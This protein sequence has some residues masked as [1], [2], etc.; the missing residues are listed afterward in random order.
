LKSET[1]ENLGDATLET[2]S[3]QALLPP[4]QRQ[5]T[6]ESTSPT[7]QENPL[8]EGRKVGGEIEKEDSNVGVP[9]ARPPAVPD[10]TA[11]ISAQKESISQPAPSSTEPEPYVACSDCKEDI[12]NI[13]FHFT[14]RICL[15]K[16]KYTYQRCYT[17]KLR[18]L[19]SADH[20]MVKSKLKE[21]EYTWASFHTPMP[22]Y[23][24]EIA[25]LSRH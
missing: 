6:V 22:M 20:K 17:K 19:K 9:D 1:N 14:C 16:E 3:S 11:S 12:P 24:K 7:F 8:E 13:E 25:S 18:C 15:E 10:A 2:T 4:Y 5:P 23:V 21:L